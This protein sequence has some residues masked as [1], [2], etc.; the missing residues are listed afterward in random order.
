MPR[1]GAT[2]ECLCSAAFLR[3]YISFS[4]MLIRLSLSLLLSFAIIMLM[5]FIVDY[6]VCF[7]DIFR[8]IRAFFAI[9]MPLIT[10]RHDTPAMPDCRYAYFSAS[11]KCRHLFYFSPP[12]PSY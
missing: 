2:R 8:L 1:A 5:L 3:V 11:V 12:S 7:F 6:Y 4:F 10:L 9:F